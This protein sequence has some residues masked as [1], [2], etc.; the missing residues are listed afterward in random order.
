MVFT[1]EGSSDLPPGSFPRNP[2]AVM[3]GFSGSKG[4]EAPLAERQRREYQIEKEGERVRENCAKSSDT[5]F[6]SGENC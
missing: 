6:K 1:N 5:T 4:F 3:M 2:R